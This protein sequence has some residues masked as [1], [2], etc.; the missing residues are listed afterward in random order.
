MTYKTII[1]E[2]TNNIQKN[3]KQLLQ[4]PEAIRRIFSSKLENIEIPRFVSS[5][6][7]ADNHK[8]NLKTEFC[9]IGNYFSYFEKTSRVYIPKH[10][11]GQYLI[12]FCFVVLRCCFG[13]QALLEGVVVVFVLV[14]PST[15]TEQIVK[16]QMPQL[17]ADKESCSQR[18]IAQ[19]FLGKK[20]E[21]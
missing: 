14:A 12:A 2:L 7:P 16:L 3:D 18:T 19:R 15:K 20:L 13:I 6:E 9:S 21:T 11:L 5:N 8:K 1:V 10:T 4:V 17:I